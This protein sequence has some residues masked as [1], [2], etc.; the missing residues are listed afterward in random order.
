MKD[1]STILSINK[2]LSEFVAAYRKCYSSSHVLIR[3]VENWKKE[4][5]NKKYVGALLMDFRLHSTRTFNSKNGCV[6]F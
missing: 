1:I 3:L 4:L 6:W 5:D 2:C